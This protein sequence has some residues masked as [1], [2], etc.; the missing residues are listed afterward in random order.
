MNKT[1]NT[2][3]SADWAICPEAMR[4]IMQY[5]LDRLDAGAIPHEA[6]EDWEERLM[7]RFQEQLVVGAEGVA[8][9]EIS[10][11][12]MPSPDLVARYFLHAADSTRIASLIR[13]AA[14]R[15][16]VKELAM[17]IN[18]PGGMV[19][20]TPEM[21]SAVRYFNSTGKVS[22]AI[23]DIQMTSAAYW[24]G[25]QATHVRVT[26]SSRIGSI[27][28][29]Q[30]HLDL[31]GARDKAGIKVEVFRAGKHKAPGAGSTSLTE[32]QREATLAAL[33]E[34]HTK[35][36]AAVS[37]GRPNISE[38]D[39]EGQVFYGDEAV[40][41]GFAD[42]TIHS[43]AGYRDGS[44]DN[45]GECMDKDQFEKISADL[46][47]AKAEVEKL[48]ADN[49]SLTGEVET[50]KGAASE[51]EAKVALE[52]AKA[53][54]ADANKAKE[55]AEAALAE[56]KADFDAK[57]AA[58]AEE[59]AKELAAEEAARIAAGS[60][61]PPIPG[62]SSSS[63]ADIEDAAIKAMDPKQLWERHSA[64][65]EKDG[66]AAANDFYTKHIRK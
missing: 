8:T 59:R 30:A 48:T 49:A 43:V 38:G 6:T 22:Y 16:D 61:V 46:A 15:D 57:V 12:L 14:M 47:A 20:G 54:T 56:A 53:E 35:F 9:L 17:I 11:P 3:L 51:N 5:D 27:G 44:V 18:S 52:A 66:Q 33:A 13:D 32:E 10:G 60:G 41:R 28:V 24:L 26:G 45:P 37:A 21:G 1:S 25:S 2:L 50:L 55:D 4:E 42:C 39:M 40:V 34:I 62:A 7:A 58:A 63:D 65:F 36:K 31:T 23:S 19:V 29:I 64:I